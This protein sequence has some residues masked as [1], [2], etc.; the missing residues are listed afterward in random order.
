MLGAFAA[1]AVASAQGKLD[2]V[3]EATRDGD[4]S[5]DDEHEHDWDWS[6][7]I[8]GDVFDDALGAVIGWVLFTPFYLP[9]MSLEDG[10]APGR[11]REYPYHDGPGYWRFRDPATLEPPRAWSLRPRVEV[12]SDFD[13]LE[14]VGL[15]LQVEHASRFGLDTSWSRWRE[16]LVGGGTDRLDLGDVNLVY[17][18]A[19]GERVAFR[20]GLGFNW[21]DDEIDSEFG[22]NATYG[23]ELFPARPLTGALEFDLGRLG[24][25]TQA[26]FR[27]E[28]GF[29]LERF[30]LFASFDHFD[31]DGVE[32]RSYG[33]GLRGWM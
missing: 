32:L 3:G 19:Q 13:D 6:A 16:E 10:G 22:L 18:F 9:R 30:G 25:A 1:G 11:F 2:R 33:L 12:G 27:A 28:L 5:D 31:I 23:V 17:R 29:V 20:A 14:R 21:L 4:A 15:G 8:E 7:D 24:D 26:H